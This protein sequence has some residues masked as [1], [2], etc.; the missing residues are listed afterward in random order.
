MRSGPNNSAE[1]ARLEAYSVAWAAAGWICLTA[2]TGCGGAA[3]KYDA[4]ATGNVLIDGQLADR[5]TVTFHPEGGGAPAVGRIRKDGSFSL[6]IGQG[7]LSEADGGTLPSGEYLITVVVTGP[8]V[9]VPD[10]PDSPPHGGPR[11][12]AEKYASTSTTDLHRKVE[13][14][15]NLFQFDL[16]RAAPVEA[17]EST[18]DTGESKE[19]VTEPA[20]DGS[21]VETPSNVQAKTNPEQKVTKPADAAGPPAAQPAL[22]DT[23]GGSL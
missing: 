22:P 14:G 13:P 2:V 10:I 11:L 9:P 7:D 1:W 17:V 18:D 6:R 3:N 8:P 12:M 19:P 20:A 21:A 15:P 4:T 23:E 5:G 16:E